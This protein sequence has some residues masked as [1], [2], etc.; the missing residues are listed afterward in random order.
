MLWTDGK[1]QG[2][3]EAQ[4]PS[5][6]HMIFYFYFFCFVKVSSVRYYYKEWKYGLKTKKEI[7]SRVILHKDTRTQLFV[8][9]RGDELE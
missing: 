4:F 2:L 9:S 1:M 5:K 7:I 3:N 8:S 6:T